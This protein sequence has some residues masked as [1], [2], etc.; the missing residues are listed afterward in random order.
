MSKEPGRRSSPNDFRETAK[1]AERAL[2]GAIPEIYE[3]GPYRLE[4]AERKLLRGIEV[5]TLTPKAFDTLYLLVRNSGHLLEKDELIRMLWPHSVVEEG[6]LTNNIFLLRK[7]LGEDPQYIETVPK[8]GYRFVGAVRRLPTTGLVRPDTPRDGESAAEV[9]G[10]RHPPASLEPTQGPTPVAV[11]RAAA[12]TVR[13][14]VFTPSPAKRVLITAIV[15]VALGAPAYLFIDKPW[16]SK[17]QGSLSTPPKG[18]VSVAPAAFAPPPHSIAVLP[19]VNLSGDP[20]QEYFSDGLTEELLIALARINELQVAARTSSFSFRGKDADISTIAHKLNVASILEGSVRRSGQTV[21]VTAQLNNAATGLHLWSQTYDRHLSDVLQLQTEIANAVASALKVTLLGDVAAK[22][23]AGGTRNPAAFDAY[24]RASK[25]YEGPESGRLPD[26]KE[27]VE[28]AVSAYAEAIHKDPDFALAYARRSFAFSLLARNYAT[29]RTQGNYL[30]KAQADARKA[31]ALAPDLAEG[32]AALGQSLHESLEFIP[33]S[34]EYER[35]LTLAPGNARILTYYGVFAVLMGRTEA[36]LAATRR[37]VVLDPLNS[38][39]HL[40]L[41]YALSIAGRYGDAVV[42]FRD[43]KTLDP[44]SGYINAQLGYAYY[45]LGDYQSARASCERADED[46]K[47]ICFAEV[48]YKLGRHA[49]AEA[50]LAKMQASDGDDGALAYAGIYLEW[51][52]R[53]HALDWLETAMR[54]RQPY[55]M[56]VRADRQWDPLREEPRFQAIERALKF[57]N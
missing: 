32:H 15:L 22:I 52:D 25:A 20:G 39:A 55:L 13:E 53:A 29:K 35:A 46:N 44:N 11:P 45:Y 33:A 14:P 12:P 2:P 50:I 8:K 27:N 56:Y 49:D 16:V 34:Q 10:A 51:G 43:A 26:R 54:L 23:E 1:S 57:P 7:A 40:E 36:G 17:H 24:L 18:P 38:F 9:S 48:Y 47:Q 6:N 19:F 31:I 30:N 4:P 37:S 3:F 42:A 28:A 21:R 41:G 5:V